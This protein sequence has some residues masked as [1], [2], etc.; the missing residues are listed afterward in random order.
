MRRIAGIVQVPD[1]E[2][3]ADA[4]SFYRIL[5]PSAIPDKDIVDPVSGKVLLQEG[6][7]KGDMGA[8]GKGNAQVEGIE[9]IRTLARKTW[10]RSDYEKYES[11]MDIAYG[12]A[13]D[14]V[15]DAGDLEAA[16]VDMLWSFPR[17]IRMVDGDRLGRD[18]QRAA[19]RFIDYFMV[20]ED[21]IPKGFELVLKSVAGNKSFVVVPK[22]KGSP[23]KRSVAEKPYDFSALDD[24]PSFYAREKYVRDTLKLQR[25]GSGSSRIVYA[26]DNKYVLK[27]AKNSAGVDQNE[28][29]SDGY[30]QEVD[31]VPHMVEESDEGLW[32][33]VE[34]A[35]KINP[36]EFERLSGMPW[37]KWGTYVR[38]YLTGGSHR[39]TPEEKKIS[40]L[41]WENEDLGEIVNVVVNMGVVGDLDRI[42]S[43]GKIDDRL[44]VA[45]LGATQAVLNTHYSPKRR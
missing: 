36:K 7:S 12:V 35:S 23:S 20:H 27:L 26:V 5:Q 10:G 22:W 38:V 1:F 11:L 4:K 28:V 30:L 19:I 18:D 45:D 43:W 15:E 33:V 29:E 39:P 24:L 31:G 21:A 32:I 16:G 3:S 2:T 40:D 25:L 44:V 34:R 37:K 13:K 42:S 14:F 6:V 17:T 41:V 9:E 8:S